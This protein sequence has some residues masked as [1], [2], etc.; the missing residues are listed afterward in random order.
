MSVNLFTSQQV[1]RFKLKSD[2]RRIERLAKE[3]KVKQPGQ[4]NPVID[5]V[6]TL[7]ELSDTAAEY[8]GKI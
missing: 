8:A 6:A 5:K 2:Y 7:P 1:I 4:C 3:H